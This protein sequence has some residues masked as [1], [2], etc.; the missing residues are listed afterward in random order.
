[1]AQDLEL[2]AVDEL[3][4]GES[5]DSKADKGEEQSVALS[6]LWLFLLSTLLL[7]NNDFKIVYPTNHLLILVSNFVGQSLQ[8]PTV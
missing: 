6:T 8:I 1:M 7:T 2:G 3:L 5:V 4:V